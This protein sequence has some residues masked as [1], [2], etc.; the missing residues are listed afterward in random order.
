MGVNAQ[1]SVPAFTNGQVL[2]AQQQTEINTGVP[3]FATTTTR[4]A[5]FG[6]TGEKVLAEG[7]LAYIEASDVV[8]YYNGTAWATLAPTSSALT[9]VTAQ[10]FTAATTISMAAGTFSSTYQNYVVVLNVTATSADQNILVR[11]NSAGSPRTAANYYGAFVYSRSDIGAILS[12]GDSAATSHRYGNI[13]TAYPL[14]TSAINV[15]DPSSA[16]TR[17]SW[18]GTFTGNM[19]TSTSIPGMGMAGAFY[20]VAEANDGL[21]FVVTGTITGTYKVYGYSNS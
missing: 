1:T 6:G 21:S 9:L 5:A 16:S 3:V 17:T 18:S 19:T 15:F 2:T 7:Q 14:F 12:S 13:A 8:Q 4:D 10:T 11:V 20:N